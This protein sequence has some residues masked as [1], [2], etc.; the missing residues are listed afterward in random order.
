MKKSIAFLLFVFNR[1][2]YFVHSDGI[3]GK[4]LAASKGT[5]V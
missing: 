2:T 5:F 1:V 3:E 4:K